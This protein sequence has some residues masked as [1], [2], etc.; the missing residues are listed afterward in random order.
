MSLI[1]MMSESSINKFVNNYQKE[2]GIPFNNE[3]FIETM[4]ENLK[5]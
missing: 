4:R 1:N 5:K 3:L 2:M